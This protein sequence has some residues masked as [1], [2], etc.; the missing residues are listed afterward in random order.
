MSRSSGADAERVGVA[1]E[2][3]EEL[4]AVLVFPLAGVDGAA[5]QADDDGHVFDAD[6]ALEL[7]G[8]AGGALEGGFLGVVLAEEGLF[9]RGAEFVEIAA[10]AE[11]DFFGVE[12]F[13]GVGGG[14]VLGAAAALDAGVGLQADELGEVLAGDEAEVFIAGERRN[15]AEA[16]AGEEDGDRAEDQVQMLGVWDEWQED[17]QRPA[18]ATHQS[19]RAARLVSVTKNDAR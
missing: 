5:A 16:A 10:D 13:A 12:S 19:I 4:G 14:A 18:C 11:D 2:G 3:D 9:G 1:F 6:R 15:I 7:A 8:S 17:Q